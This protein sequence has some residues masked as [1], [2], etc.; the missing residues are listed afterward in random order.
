MRSL[1]PNLDAGNRIRVRFP[2]ILTQ[3][4]IAKKTSKNQLTLPKKV[5]ERFPGVDYFD[6]RVDEGTITL[7][8]VRE[9]R[10]PRVQ[11]RLERLGLSDQDIRDAVAW[12][13]SRR[14]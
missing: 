10:L 8:P 2:Y 3:A 11:A 7:V 14:R 5:V 4:M 9:D 13:R 6:V 12:A 1:T